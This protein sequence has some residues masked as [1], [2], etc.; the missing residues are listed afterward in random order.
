MEADELMWLTDQQVQT[1]LQAAIG[2][3][4]L[5][6]VR[7]LLERGANASDLL[8]EGRTPLLYAIQLN[9]VD[10]IPELV[11]YGA[12][13]NAP[14]RKFGET[15]LMWACSEGASPKVVQALLDNGARI[16]STVE[17]DAHIASVAQSSTALAMAYVSQRRELIDIL[18]A[19]GARERGFL[20]VVLYP[21]AV[22]AEVQARLKLEAGAIVSNVLRNSAADVAAIQRDDAIIELAGQPVASQDDLIRV[23]AS[24]LAGDRLRCVVVR[25]GQQIEVTIELHPS[26]RAQRKYP[27]PVAPATTPFHPHQIV[28]RVERPAL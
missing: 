2:A 1:P 20:G 21:S 17:A 18:L 3:K 11:K 22:S 15:P 16:D 7:L 6:A 12:D 24:R 8:A 5:A 25:Q 9:A 4:N 14:E 28:V 19:H 23:M 13:I 26:C 10:L 27:E